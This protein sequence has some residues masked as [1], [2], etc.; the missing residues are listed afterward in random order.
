M[1][2]EEGWV[3]CGED[4]GERRLRQRDIWLQLMRFDLVV[5]VEV[6]ARARAFGW[7]K[8]VSWFSSSVPSSIT[9]SW[10]VMVCSSWW[11]AVG[12]GAA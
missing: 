6:V 7:E 12:L 4:S 3:G 10:V 5:V 9:E 11:L 1:A 2:V 8:W